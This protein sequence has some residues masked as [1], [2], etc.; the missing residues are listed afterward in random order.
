VPE[1][2]VVRPTLRRA[3]FGAAV[4]GVLFLA[5]AFLTYVFKDSVAWWI[6]FA[7]LIPFIMP[8]AAWIEHKRVRLTLA[9]RTLTFEQGFFSTSMRRL[10]TTKIQDV[11]VERSLSERMWGVGTLILETAGEDGRLVMHDVDRPLE[12]ADRILNASRTAGSEA[13]L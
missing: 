9:G 13:K 1:D 10:D 8:L 7:G 6:I 2:L 5:I 12:V 3:K 4:A 11:R